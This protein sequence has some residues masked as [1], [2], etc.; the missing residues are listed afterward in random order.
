LAQRDEVLTS[1][2]LAKTESDLQEVQSQLDKLASRRELMQGQKKAQADK[3]DKLRSRIADLTVQHEDEAKQ[4]QK[5]APDSAPAATEVVDAEQLQQAQAR[6]KDTRVEPKRNRPRRSWRHSGRNWWLSS[7]RPYRQ[8]E[9]E[10][11]RKAPRGKARRRT[12]PR[13]LGRCNRLFPGPA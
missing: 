10:P 12:M 7:K 2:K 3:L 13:P 5:A 1:N 4:Q 8:I 9:S 6:E 11:P